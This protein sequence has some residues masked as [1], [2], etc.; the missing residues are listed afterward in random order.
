MSAKTVRPLEIADKPATRLPGL[1]LSRVRGRW[2]G[3]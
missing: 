2:I 3:G 1:P